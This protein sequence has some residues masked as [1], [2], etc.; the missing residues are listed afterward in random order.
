MTLTLSLVDAVSVGAAPAVFAAVPA[1]YLVIGARHTGSVASPDAALR[2]TVVPRSKRDRTKRKG[3]APSTDLVHLLRYSRLGN[4]D[5]VASRR[6]FLHTILRRSRI[7]LR[8][9]P[10]WSQ[11]PPDLHRR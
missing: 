1:A 4:C 11:L 8:G 6:W 10:P 2:G 7:L 9:R 5:M 3:A